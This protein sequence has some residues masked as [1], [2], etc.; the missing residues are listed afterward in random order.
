MF[1]H[2]TLILI[3]LGSV[4]AIASGFVKGFAGFGFAVVFTP[5][6]SIIF[7]NP[8]EVV[9]V[10]L[11]LGAIMSLGVVAEVRHSITK[12]RT[13]PVVIGTAVGTPI[14][15]VLLGLIDVSTLKLIIASIA[16]GVTLLRLAKLKIRIV[17]GAKPLAV[18]A[19]LGGILNGCTSMGGPI[20][21]LI[22]AWQNRGIDE[23][24]SILVVFNLLS[25]LLAI[26]VAL[27]TGVAQLPWLLS[28]IW[29]FPPAAI[30][31]FAGVH[32][33]RHISQKTFSHV[34]TAVVGLA[35]VAGVLSVLK[36]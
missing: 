6:C 1:L 30:G 31:T 10:A 15:I 7:D 21:A 35:G 28:G 24:R 12:D 4:V 36:I 16:I 2:P 13:T 25:Y 27:G 14:G 19:L 17:A 8:R 33:V 26:A 23:S 18:G 22:V 9:F 34:I 11:V 29:L 5:L 3:I 20:P 32:A